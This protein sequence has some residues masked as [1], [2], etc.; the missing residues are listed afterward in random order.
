MVQKSIGKP[1]VLFDE[2][3]VNLVKYKLLNYDLLIY[4]KHKHIN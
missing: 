2:Q 3:S 4:N 1:L